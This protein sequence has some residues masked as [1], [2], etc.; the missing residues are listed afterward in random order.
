MGCGSAINGR[1]IKQIGGMTRN[2]VKALDMA[3]KSIVND[4]TIPSKAIELM[5]SKLFPVWLYTFF[6]KSR[7]ENSG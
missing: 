1:P 6:W 5:S 3:A 2:I 4:D 7:L